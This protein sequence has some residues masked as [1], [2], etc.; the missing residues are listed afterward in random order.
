[1]DRF[2]FLNAVHSQFIEDMYQQYLK[3]PDSL[4]PS[5]KAF[6]QGFDFAL[7]NYSDEEAVQEIKSFASQ[8]E[9]SNVNISEISEDIRRE[10]K[11]INLIEAYRVR[12]HLFTKTNPVRERRHFEPT[13]DIENFGLTSADLNR[14]FNS[15]TETGMPGPATLS[16]I[17]RHL[18]NIYCDSIGVEYMYIKNVEERDFIRQWLQVNENHAKLSPEEKKHVLQRLNQAVAFENYLHTKFV[19]QKRFSLEGLEALIP[20]LDQVITKSSQLGVDEVVLG[21]AHRGRLNVLT[22]I[23]QKPYK[24]IFSEF[25]GKEFEEDVF[26]GDVKYHLGASKVIQTTA[27]ETVKIN[28]TPNPSHLETVASLVEGISRAKVDNSYNGDYNKILPIV[29]HGDAAI[30][31]QGIVYEVA[32]MMTLD[33]YK[34]GG[35]I[36]IVTNNQVGFTTNYLDARSST[37]CT[38]VAKVTDSP[39]MHINADDVEAVV[40]AMH[41]AADFRNRFGKDVYIDLLGYR[42]YGHNE[43]D[44]PKFT[45]PKLYNIIAKHPNPREIYKDKLIKEG[46]VSDEVMKQ[47]EVEFKKLLDENFDES[48][49]IKKN[50]MDIFMSDDWKKFPFGSRGSVLNPVDT[51]FPLDKLKDLAKQISTL[52]TDKKFIKKIT[53]LFEQRLNMVENDSLDWAMG[54]L[55]AYA[56]LLSEEFGIRISGE[57]VERGTFSHRHA[58]VKTEDTEE[59]Y[60]PLKSVTTKDNQFQ[61]YNSL[62]S[63]YAV[64]GFDYGYA[65]VSP[66][67]LT[68]WEAQFGDFANG[69]QIIIDQYLVAAEEKWKLQNGLVMLL[70]HGSEGQGAEHSSARL[71]RFLTLCA[72]QNIIVTNATTPANYFHLLRRQMKADFRKPLVVM[73]PKS[74]LRHPRAVSKVEELANGAFQPIIDDATAKADKVERLVLCSGKLYYELLAKKEE[75]NDEKVALVRLEQLYP[76]QMDQLDAVFEK[77]SNAKE[78]IWAQEEPENMGAWSYILRNLRDRNPQ[79][80][81]PVASGAPAPGSHKKFEINQNAIINQVFQC[82]GT[83]AKRPVTA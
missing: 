22:N 23:F 50:T 31:G 36:H 2:S 52:P 15:A 11:V 12:G 18:Q 30:A 79:V 78:F 13:L 24:Q 9:N 54:E 29:I 25:E 80:I 82:E 1:M 48:K 74:L 66:D 81:S 10:F 57:D 5:W 41:F 35:T 39:V 7:E 44:E 46:I 33:G 67:T 69:A 17:I 34:T 75:L 72:N 64:L 4:E 26:S 45:Q 73:T 60:V 77:Y 51:K 70:P 42:K 63:E 71:E 20:A 27:G 58:V 40:H 76:L 6:F 55:L 16:E 83:P 56:T 21:M 49:E 65:M 68:I 14:K 61:I 28:L 59:E 62:L 53:R 43:G 19:G 8:A 37:Y 32:Q 47:M 3:Y 38:D